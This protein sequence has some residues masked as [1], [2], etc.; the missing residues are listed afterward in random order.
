MTGKP[1]GLFEYGQ[2]AQHADEG[3]ARRT[4]CIFIDYLLN[5]RGATAVMSYSARSRPFAPIAV[6][7]TWRNCAISTRLPIG[8]SEAEMLKG[9]SSKNLAHWGRADQ[10]LPDL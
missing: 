2:G 7:L 9:A 3:K 8:I 4:G 10:I 5:Q 1:I 6:L